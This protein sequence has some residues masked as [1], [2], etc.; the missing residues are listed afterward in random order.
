MERGHETIPQIF[1]SIFILSVSEELFKRC[2][3]F[4]FNASLGQPFFSSSSLFDQDSK[5][6]GKVD[7]I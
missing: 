6:G 2:R 1:L 3:L 4:V 7:F 5:G